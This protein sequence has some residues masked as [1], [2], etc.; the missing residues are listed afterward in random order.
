MMRI[1][2]FY[3]ELQHH[4]KV[5][6]KETDYIIVTAGIELNVPFN[7]EQGAMIYKTESD[8]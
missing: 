6:P 2:V 1:I 4:R 3:D 8:H 5:T 7:Q